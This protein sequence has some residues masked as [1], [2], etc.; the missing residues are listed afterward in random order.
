MSVVKDFTDLK[1]NHFLGAALFVFSFICPG[2][3]LIFWL[4]LELFKSLEVVKLILLALSITAPT[5]FGGYV[6]SHIAYSF[7]GH[8]EIGAK[9]G[10]PYQ[11]YVKHAGMTGFIAYSIL[12]IMYL[13]SLVNRRSFDT[14]KLIYLVSL[15]FIP[16]IIAM[17]R[18]I[19]ET[20][21]IFKTHKDEP[22]D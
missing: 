2:V 1:H 14:D 21:K 11:W 12:G 9:L 10:T 17:G 7:H 19:L 15:I 4:D 22:K 6:I 8:K 18:E 20:W 13:L 5:F 3:L 16:A